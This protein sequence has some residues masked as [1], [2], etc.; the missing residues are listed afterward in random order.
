M[1][2]VKP[3]STP[4]FFTMANLIY[5]YT[6]G[7]SPGGKETAF[8]GLPPGLRIPF[9]TFHNFPEG[10]FLTLSNCFKMAVGK[11]G[12]AKSAQ[13]LDQG[14]VLH[15]PEGCLGRI[16]KEQRFH[17]L[18]PRMLVLKEVGTSGDPEC[19]QGY[20]IQCERME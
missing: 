12:D 7:N 3:L 5:S 16:G 6:I 10:P 14:R 15:H 19:E 17:P 13:H 11:Y 20:E 18:P 4:A 9:F 1:V 8:C 2:R